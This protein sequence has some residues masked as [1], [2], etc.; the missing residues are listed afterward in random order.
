VTPEER[1]LRGRIGA[2]A[3]HSRGLTNT[4][5]ARAAFFERFER[6]VDPEGTLAPKVRA[7]RADQARRAHMARLA[8]LSSQARRARSARRSRSR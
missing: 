7:R 6:E 4:G 1:S 3:L 8:L 5:P 2:F